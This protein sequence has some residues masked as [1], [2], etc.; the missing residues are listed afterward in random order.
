MTENRHARLAAG[1]ILALVLSVYVPVIRTGGFIWDDPQYVTGNPLL[2]T[3][4]GLLAIWIHPLA[5]PQY[6]P[7]VHT[8][9][10]IEYHLVGLH[11]ALYHVDN[12][13]LHAL[14]SILLW[15]ALARLGVPGA[16]LAAAIFA[17]HPVQVESV[18]WVT[19]RKNVLSLVFYLLAFHAY[20]NFTDRSKAR[21][22]WLA[23]GLFIGA[24]LS[25]SVTCSLPAAILLIVYW[26]TGRV[27]WANVR[28]LAAFFLLGAVMAAVTAMLEKKHVGA[29]GPEWSFTPADRCL[30]A[31]RALWFYAAK[32]L[33]P[34]PLIFIYPRW[35][36][37]DFSRR[38]W[39][40]LFP[41]AA[42]GA[43]AA[44]WLLR[45]GIGRGPLV[46]VL[47]FAGT[48]LPALGFINLYPMR[49]SF[50]ADHFQYQA[51]IGLIVLAAAGLKR[52]RAA[53][54]AVILAVLGVL[55]WQRGSVYQN[56]LVLW[57]DTVAR[58]PASWM[59]WGNL[60]DEYADLSNRLDLPRAQR[61]QDRAEARRCYATLYKLAPDQ[62]LAH[63]KWG[64]VKEYDGDLGAAKD[65]F[66]AALR[67]A[68]DFTV[69]MN[70]MGMLL[71]RQN[72]PE[73]AM[74]YYR[75]AV[76]LDPGYAEARVNYGNA[77]LSRGDKDGAFSQ[78]SQAAA[79]RPDNVEA[80]FKLANMLFTEK[81]RA[82]LAIPH[83]AAAVSVD[84]NRA[85]IR[86]NLA[87]A[88]MAVG[89][90][91]EAKEQCQE[92]LRLAPDLPQ[93]RQLWA[94]LAGQ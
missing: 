22:Y 60:G 77:L 90:F 12:V 64:I 93:A 80:Q 69:A 85:D 5:L 71:M 68:P 41:L 19:E 62:P 37:M 79:R 15:R 73:E 56:P 34:H 48:L 30:I 89:R 25:K 2:R 88:L 4:P 28:P 24:L 63:L 39:L 49:Y 3:L 11:P 23:L 31:G 10:W 94:K 72:R 18:A 75:R 70:S 59:A 50:V 27:R 57:K 53:G 14:G 51:S 9:F 32:L 16:W 83:Y 55:T 86:T 33:W 40:I 58:N 46:A 92:A 36:A 13:L 29:S 35:E 61:E 84:P 6:Y 54:A 76:E 26:Q 45:R 87:A 8:T 81:N 52:L 91:E 42:L 47:F 7:L 67:L 66:A 74:Q 20:L 38:P 78:Y 17:V 1:A 65:E 43:I 82:D 21:D 44:L